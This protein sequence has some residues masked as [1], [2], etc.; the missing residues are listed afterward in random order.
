MEQFAYRVRW[1][2]NDRYVLWVCPSDDEIGFDRVALND[3]GQIVLAD[4]VENLRR[5]HGLSSSSVEPCHGDTLDLDRVV[6][7]I[8]R[9]MKAGIACPVFLDAW[10][11]FSDLRSAIDG[12][13]RHI[14]DRREPSLYNKL[15]WG[16]NLPPVTPVGCHYVPY[17]TVSEVAR[18]RN[19]LMNGLAVFE[20]HIEY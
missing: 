13:V 15:F 6:R 17:W 16:C 1:A 9:P 5:R 18:L 20:K 8:A 4:S 12:E 10:N 14:D 11:F 2:A 7:W 19:V 3:G